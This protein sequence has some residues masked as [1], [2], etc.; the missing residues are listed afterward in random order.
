MRKNLKSLTQNLKSLTQN[1][2][3]FSLPFFFQETGKSKNFMEILI[4]VFD[5]IYSDIFSFTALFS[6]K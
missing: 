2:S 1:L 3:L 4:P 6:K 5:I